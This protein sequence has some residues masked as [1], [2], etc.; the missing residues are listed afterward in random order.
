MQDLNIMSLDLEFNQPSESIIQVGV[1]VGNLATGDIL[2]RYESCVLVNEQMHPYITKLTGIKQQDVDNG[3]LLWEVYRDI[4]ELHQKHNCFINVL[5][6]GGGDSQ[7]LRKELGLE[8]NNFVFGR[9]W[10]DA[11]TI[12]VS[13][14]FVDDVKHQSGLPKSMRRLGMN[15]EGR[16]HTAVDDAYNT[17]RIYRKLLQNFKKGIL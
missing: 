3:K 14:C 16:K 17:F 13:Q 8:D 15:F 5:T 7:A 1:V 9:R 6:W 12:F 4:R 2:D 10:I 11:K